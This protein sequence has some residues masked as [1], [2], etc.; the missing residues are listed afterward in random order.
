MSERFYFRVIALFA[1]LNGAI[2]FSKAWLLDNGAHHNVLLIGNLALG[3]LSLV[4]YRMSRKGIHS[5]NNTTF[6]TRVY[7]AKIARIVL[8]L[9]GIGVYVLLN[10][11][12]VSKMTIFILMFF[13]AAYAFT[14]NMSLQ[15]V[16]R[17]KK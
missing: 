9:A 12:H 5:A 8:C 10:R 16:T 13:Y 4:T 15:Q 3:I 2:I 17:R 1:V 7:G 11:A 6:V 14:E